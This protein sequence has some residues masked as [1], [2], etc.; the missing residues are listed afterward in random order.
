MNTNVD[1]NV[2]TKINTNI[3][4]FYIICYNNSF[5]VE[6]Q[7]KTISFFCKD[8]HKIII[9]DSN[10]G[11]FKENSIEKQKIC[12]KYNIEYLT[13]PEHLSLDN[14]HPSVILGKKLNYVYYELILKRNPKYFSFLDQDFFMIK[15]FSII[16]HLDKY[17]MYGD[18]SENGGEKS[19]SF[20]KKDVKDTPWVLHPWCSFYKLDFIKDYKMN[21][22]PCKQFDT[23]G[24][25]WESFVKLKKLNKKD[26]WFRDNI[27]M[28]YPFADISNA[29]PPPYEKH[30]CLYNCK[31]FYGQLQINN[32][33]LH[34]LNSC[35]LTEPLHPKS[36]FCKG[37]LD[38]ILL[39]SGY[40]F[41][42][43]NGYETFDSPCDKLV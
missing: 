19:D 22:L 5:C 12:D 28:Y 32:S 40:S 16:E 33:F 41:N 17:G 27:I 30:Y 1:T 4:E 36:A 38:G 3:I 2:D 15:S 23:G 31:A 26:Y 8:S 25:N 6:Y 11:K 14:E 21:W 35:T 34:L 37:M 13:L 18:L 39:S 10:C 42:K 20:Y 24:E 43:K 7:I 29:G 9:I